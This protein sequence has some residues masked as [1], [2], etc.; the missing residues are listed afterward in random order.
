MSEAM[1]VLKYLF[2]YLFYIRSLHIHSHK[3]GISLADLLQVKFT[4]VFYRYL[5]CEYYFLGQNRALTL[6]MGS[7]NKIN[8]TERGTKPWLKSP[9][10]LSRRAKPSAC[11]DSWIRVSVE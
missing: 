1:L 7:D 8:G 2:L 3:N 10:T 9:L 11:A 5:L 6:T 4:G